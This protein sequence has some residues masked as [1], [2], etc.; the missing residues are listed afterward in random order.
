MS[1]GP[2]P[3]YYVPMSTSP[4]ERIEVVDVLR[5]F[6]LFGIMVTHSGM[7]FLVGPTPYEN[8]GRVH[9]F[10]PVVQQVVSL[11]TT[12]KFFMIFSFLFGLSFA[13][14]IDNA[15][16]KGTA[17]AGRF[18]WRL[19]VLL[20]IGC[21]HSS[22]GAIDDLKWVLAADPHSEKEIAELCHI[23]RE[24]KDFGAAVAH[25]RSIAP[26][27]LAGV[28]DDLIAGTVD[29]GCAMWPI[30]ICDLIAGKDVL[31]VGCGSG[32]HGLSF[33]MAGKV[34]HRARSANRPCEQQ[35]EA[36]VTALLD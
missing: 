13:I 8:F 27:Q 33:I 21:V 4:N 26:N 35:G 10:D 1:D 14:Q 32:V 16:R 20:L 36:Q 24:T 28:P 22:S 12:G 17:F 18:A 7:E 23:A 31:D 29:F 2:L 5:A 30:T 19:T 9:S 11:L 3:P 15:A 34:V 25:L 6:A